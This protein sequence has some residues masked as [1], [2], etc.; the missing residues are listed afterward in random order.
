[1]HKRQD[2]QASITTVETV[3][4]SSTRREVFQQQINPPTIENFSIYEKY[5]R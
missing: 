3:R 2:M 4:N 5:I 1:M